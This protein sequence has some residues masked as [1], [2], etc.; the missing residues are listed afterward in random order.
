MQYQDTYQPTDHEEYMNP[1]Q[2]EYFRNRLLNWRYELMSSSH[3]VKS[4]LKESTVNTPDIFDVASKYHELEH[5][6]KDMERARAR[7]T[8]IDK[9]LEKINSG[10]YGYCELTGD[11]IGIGR[12][13]AQ[14]VATLCIEVQETLEKN[15][16]EIGHQPGYAF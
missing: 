3:S 7:L 13:Q 8:L 10:D 12:L 5:D 11:E 6:I 16:R 1:R 2:V 4:D 15:N 14:P 9:A